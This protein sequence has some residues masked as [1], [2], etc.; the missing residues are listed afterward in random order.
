MNSITLTNTSTNTLMY[1]KSIKLIMIFIKYM[2]ILNFY[3]TLYMYK[4][5]S[6]QKLISVG[7]YFFNLKTEIMHLHLHNFFNSI[8]GILK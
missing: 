6:N 8:F 7:I 5:S 1:L 4:Y 3:G 2:H